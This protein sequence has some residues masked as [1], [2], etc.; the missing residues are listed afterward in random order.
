MLAFRN[1]ADEVLPPRQWVLGAPTFRVGVFVPSSRVECLL[2]NLVGSTS[3]EW[4][5]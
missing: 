5:G 2:F 3:E 1:G 4:A